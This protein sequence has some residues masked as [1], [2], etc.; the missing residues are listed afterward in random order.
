ML[1]GPRNILTIAICGR[2]A[3]FF[4]DRR[5]NCS[6][7]VIRA[8]LQ[9]FTLQRWPE[10]DPMPARALARMLKKELKVRVPFLAREAVVSGE[11]HV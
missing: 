2:P 5:W 9:N 3:Y 11:A 6:D 10:D 8:T 4:N 7:P 1:K